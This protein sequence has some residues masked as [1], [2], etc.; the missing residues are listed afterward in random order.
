MKNYAHDH[1][2]QGILKKALDSAGIDPTTQCRVF[3]HKTE[4]IVTIGFRTDETWCFF[5]VSEKSFSD[6][7]EL[8]AMIKTRVPYMLQ[9][10]KT[11]Q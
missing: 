10:V 5:D 6:P 1:P 2:Y 8:T 4:G 3:E 11:A 7:I 9:K